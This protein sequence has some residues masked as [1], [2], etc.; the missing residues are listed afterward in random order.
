[1]FECLRFNGWGVS[2]FLGILGKVEFFGWGLVEFDLCGIVD[3]FM[4]M[5]DL[6]WKLSDVI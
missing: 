4:V 1:M 3:M 6:M 5:E 2:L